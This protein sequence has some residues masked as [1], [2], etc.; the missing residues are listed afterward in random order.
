MSQKVGE[1]LLHITFYFLFN[2]NVP[3]HGL[4]ILVSLLLSLRAGKILGVNQQK[5]G[6]QDKLFLFFLHSAMLYSKSG[7]FPNLLEKDRIKSQIK[8][9]LTSF[10]LKLQSRSLHSGKDKEEERESS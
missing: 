6:R 10:Y 7:P 8:A 4:Q 1:H 3:I 9:Y 5:A 2:S